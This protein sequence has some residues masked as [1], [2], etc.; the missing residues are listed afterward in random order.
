[1]SIRVM[2][3][4]RVY[5]RTQETQVRPYHKPEPSDPP[6]TVWKCAVCGQPWLFVD[7]AD[8]TRYRRHYPGTFWERD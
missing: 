5:T 6:K 4:G 8:G 2:I 7:R 1:M 3:D